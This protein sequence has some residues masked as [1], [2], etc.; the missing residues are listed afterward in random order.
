MGKI[1]RVGEWATVENLSVCYDRKYCVHV[2]YVSEGGGEI[3]C[4]E[5]LLDKGNRKGKGV[6]LMQSIYI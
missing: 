6:G 5:L 1:T 2:W 3:L 4:R